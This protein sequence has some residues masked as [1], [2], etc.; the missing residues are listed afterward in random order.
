MIGASRS[1]HWLGA[2]GVGNQVLAQFDQPVGEPAPGAVA[3]HAV[4]DQRPG[5]GL[6]V[7]DHQIGIG[8]K[9]FDQRPRKA[10][11]GIPENADLP[12]PAAPRQTGVKLWMETSSGTVP[13]AIDRSIVRST[14]A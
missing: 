6:V 14:S 10:G 9:R 5:I 12:R 1:T 11:I 8:G 2:G 4:A 7:A 13:A 3:I